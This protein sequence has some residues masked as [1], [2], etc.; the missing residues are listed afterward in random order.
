[1]ILQMYSFIGL[2]LRIIWITKNMQISFLVYLHSHCLF[3]DWVIMGIL[4]FIEA[5][6]N[7]LKKRFNFSSNSWYLTRGNKYDA[8]TN[9]FELTQNGIC[10]F[11]YCL[12]PYLVMAYLNVVLIS[13]HAFWFYR[14]L[15]LIRVSLKMKYVPGDPRHVEKDKFKK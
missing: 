7:I 9:L 1:M 11:H 5:S 6:S 2:K 10:A 12:D 4:L 13:L 14:C 15:V 3:C 8:S